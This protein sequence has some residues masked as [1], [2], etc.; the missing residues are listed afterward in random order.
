MKNVKKIMVVTCLLAA[1]ISIP[2]YYAFAQNPQQGSTVIE[3]VTEPIV[4]AAEPIVNVA[5][6]LVNSV[7]ADEAQA[8]L[9]TV[10]Y[11]LDSVL[12]YPIFGVPALVLWLI[13]GGIF[14][15]LYLRFVNVRLF[16]H[17]IHV[18]RGKY[19]KD[20]DP[21]EITHFQALATAVSA[22][23]G[24]GNIAGVAVAVTVGGP[25]AIFWM[26]VGGLFGMSTKF[27]EVTM[28]QKYR[29]INKKTGKVSGG[30]FYYLSE[31]LRKQRLPNLGKYL[32]VL[33]AI[34]C[35]GGSFG[36]GNMFQ[37]NQS[38][39]ALTNTFTFLETFDWLLAIVLAV[40]I[41]IVLLGGIKRIAKVAGRVVP[42][43]AVFYITACLII[44]IINAEA[45]PDAI[46]TIFNSAFTGS[47]VAGG[48]LGTLIAGIKR[49]TFSNEAGLGSAPI[50]HAAAKTR[51]PVREGCVALLEPFI[52]T[53]VICFITGTVITVTGVYQN[54]SIE[55]GVMLTQAAFATVS[56]WF[57]MLLSLAVVLFAFSTIITWS[58]YG[59]RAW[60]YLFGSRSVGVYH[61]IFCTFTF[62]GGIVNF[63]VILSFSDLLLFLMAAP[64]LLGLYIMRTEIK[65]DVGRYIKKLDAGKFKPVR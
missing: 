47:S 22:T 65:R 43:M 62:L 57:P 1:L 56:D 37:A 25:G 11:I 42:F 17:A 32:A 15:T 19:S 35:I 59:E 38:I 12:F 55:G 2:S 36:A 16:R 8:G 23:V 39:A 5:A 14:F 58:Y 26:G 9:E 44:L 46:A 20:S 34:T 21:G 49:S 41:A 61:V 63:G 27:A 40:S 6:P 24:L 10:V 4:D 54:P 50:A 3:E 30:A 64:N 51:E 60:E 33:F 31:G 13:G 53:I 28:G 52:D 29:K 45:V 7:I 48:F 18:V